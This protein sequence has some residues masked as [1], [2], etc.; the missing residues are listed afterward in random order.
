MAA[1]SRCSST[2]PTNPTLSVHPESSLCDEVV[3]IEANGLS[4]GQ[5]VTLKAHVYTENGKYRFESR[6]HYKA[7]ADG[8]VRVQKEPS[9]GGSYEGIEPMGLFLAMEPVPEVA[10]KYPRLVKWDVTT[11][12]SYTLELIDG[13]EG[14]EKVL[15]S[16]SF[17]RMFLADYVERIPV[18]MGEAE[19]VL[20]LPK[21]RGSSDP[22]PFIIDIRGLLTNLVVDRAATLASHGFAVFAFDYFM[23]SRRKSQEETVYMDSQAFLGIIDFVK[24]HPRLDENRIGMTSSCYGGAMMLHAATRLDLPVKCMVAAGFVDILCVNVGW[25]NLDGSLL[26]PAGPMSMYLTTW[27]DENGKS[28]LTLKS[29][30]DSENFIDLAKKSQSANFC[31]E[32]NLECPLLLFA[33]ADDHHI[34]SLKATTELRDRLEKAGKGHLVEFEL[35]PGTGHFLEVPYQA[36]NTIS[37]L[38]DPTTLQSPKLY[39][40]DFG[41]SDTKQGTKDQVFAWRKIVNFF[42]KHLDVKE[43]YRSDWIS[44]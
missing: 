19:G 23:P 7:D 39:L 14:Q 3:N 15:T 40:T 26:E 9:L 44:S 4:P 28:W 17:E 33:H 5:L 42:R 29:D 6:A 21:Q 34:P 8:K 12:F 37:S 10:H 32:E 11:P 38:Y 20:F 31:L 36:I 30:T 27:T 1:S 25:K 2:G 18:K 41:G 43:M 13:D 24:A 35:L 22:L 16:T